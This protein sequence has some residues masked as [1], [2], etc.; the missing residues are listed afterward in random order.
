MSVLDSPR[1]APRVARDPQAIDVPW[2]LGRVRDWLLG[3]T[4]LVTNLALFVFATL[5][6]VLWQISQHPDRL[7]LPGWVTVW[8]VLVAVH[9]GVVVSY[10]TL[11]AW[12]SP[13]RGP[14]YYHAIPP[15]QRSSA[16]PGRS[17]QVASPPLAAPVATAR[18]TW[19]GVLAPVTP[20]P[21]LR[22]SD[23]SGTD[24][25]AA[26]DHDDVTAVHPAG[27]NGPVW[28]ASAAG[29]SA[30]ADARD[31]L[32][33]DQP[34]WRRWRRRPSSTPDSAPL[35]IGSADSWLSP[36]PGAPPVT[37][38]RPSASWLPSTTGEAAPTGAVDTTR[39]TPPNDRWPTSQSPRWEPLDPPT[40][41]ADGDQLPS[42]AAMLRA[43]NLTALSDAPITSGGPRPAND[44]APTPTPM[45]AIPTPLTRRSGSTSPQPKTVA[46]FAA[47]GID[48]DGRPARTTSEDAT[49]D[50]DTDDAPADRNRPARTPDSR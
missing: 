44:A 12:R 10:G 9:A 14:V 15:E 20:F 18:P 2:A 25:P 37:R 24:L 7:S 48:G 1:Q 46:L 31:V 33:S 21:T 32:A 8:G 40:R 26:P 39:M 4:P 22:A 27:S 45:P 42:L 11:R 16:R 17:H 36:F 29:D 6:T 34:L 47:F 43:N 5:G 41:T 30:L 28:P 38:S 49:T 35:P 50:T 23:R 13:R 3:P 19:N